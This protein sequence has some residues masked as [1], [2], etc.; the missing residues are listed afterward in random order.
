LSN[1]I[2]ELL[3]EHSKTRM[4]A[5]AS[6]ADW[7]TVE[8]ELAKIPKGLQSPFD[9]T[10]EAWVAAIRKGERPQAAPVSAGLRDG[11]GRILRHHRPVARAGEGEVGRLERRLADLVFQAYGLDADQIALVWR[12]APPRMPVQPPLPS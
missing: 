6:L 9:L 3:S 5:A 4:E 11:A 10:E 7:L 2:V 1:E 12:T 8:H